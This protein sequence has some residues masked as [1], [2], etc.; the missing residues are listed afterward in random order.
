MRYN[1]F[2]FPHSPQ[3]PCSPC[4]PC[5]PRSP[6]SPCSPRSPCSPCSPRSPRSPCSPATAAPGIFPPASA[7]VLLPLLSFPLLHRASALAPLPDTLLL[8]L[9]RI[10][11]IDETSE[12][13]KSVKT[14]RLKIWIGVNLRKKEKSVRILIVQQ[15]SKETYRKNGQ[16]WTTMG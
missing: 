2:L 13:A 10:Y 15:F 9:T 8:L 12:I 1:A 16:F 3:S 6:C 14:Y 7:R 4:S 11:K 5:S